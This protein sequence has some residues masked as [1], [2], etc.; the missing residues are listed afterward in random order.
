MKKGSGAV[1][2]GIVGLVGLAALGCATTPRAV[3]TDRVITAAELASLSSVTVF[4]AIGK[5]RPAWLGPPDATGAGHV[6]PLPSVYMNRLYLG[7]PGAL[8]SVRVQDVVE[9]RLVPPS[10]ARDRY[11]ARN[12]AGAIELVTRDVGAY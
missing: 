3:A 5:L 4:E 12:P 6:T 1:T 7:D 8:G 2:A 11:G 9:V 10:V